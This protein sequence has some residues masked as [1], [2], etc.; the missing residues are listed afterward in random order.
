MPNRERLY[1]FLLG[2]LFANAILSVALFSGYLVKPSWVVPENAMVV[3]KDFITAIQD[4]H[5]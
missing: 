3:A 5:K 4:K 2:I 1:I